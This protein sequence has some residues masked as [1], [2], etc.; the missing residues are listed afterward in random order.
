MTFRN[1]YKFK[2]RLVKPGL[3]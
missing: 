3:V 2:K 1:V